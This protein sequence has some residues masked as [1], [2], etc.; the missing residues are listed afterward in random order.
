[1]AKEKTPEQKKKSLE[2]K[3]R[4]RISDMRTVMGT[5][6]GRR[7]VWDLLSQANVYQSPSTKAGFKTN[8]TFFEDGKRYNGLMLHADV[9]TNTPQEYLLMVQENAGK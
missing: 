7:F 4:Q 5:A 2:L 6:A 3:E 1:M 9:T 8:E